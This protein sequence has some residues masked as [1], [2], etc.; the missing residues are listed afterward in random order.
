[1]LLHQFD[2]DYMPSLLDDEDHMKGAV[3]CIQRIGAHSNWR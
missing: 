1:M 2:T 3:V